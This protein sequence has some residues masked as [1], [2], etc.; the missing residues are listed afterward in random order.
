[1][2]IKSSKKNKLE[3]EGVNLSNLQSYE[4]KK[5]KSPHFK[6]TRSKNFLMGSQSVTGI[7]IEVIAE[8]ED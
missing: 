8:D 5:L 2:A 1:M 7:E 4:V 3:Y 6:Q